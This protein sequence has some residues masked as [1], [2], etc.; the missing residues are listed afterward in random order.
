MIIIIILT[1]IDN[2]CSSSIQSAETVLFTQFTLFWCNDSAEPITDLVPEWFRFRMKIYRNTL[3]TQHIIIYNC[4][5][6]LQAIN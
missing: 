3:L 4:I 5:Q 2:W 1:R 6:N